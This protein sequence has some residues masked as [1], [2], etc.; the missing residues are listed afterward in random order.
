MLSS[1]SIFSFLK[2]SRQILIGWK[3]FICRCSTVNHEYLARERAWAGRTRYGDG[4]SELN[5]SPKVQISQVCSFRTDEGSRGPP[6]VVDPAVG[7][8]ASCLSNW[9][10]RAR[11]RK[12]WCLLFDRLVMS[13]GEAQ[14]DGVQSW[15]SFHYRFD[16]C[17]LH[18]WHPVSNR[19]PIAQV[20]LRP[21]R[22]ILWMIVRLAGAKSQHVATKAQMLLALDCMQPQ[23]FN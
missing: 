23:V 10:Q 4:C 2:W 21:L 19:I 11:H 22:S 12:R 15:P 6:E 17:A 18:T 9:W 14:I 20:T 1:N 16:P 7:W 13:W 8:T 5:G 3:C